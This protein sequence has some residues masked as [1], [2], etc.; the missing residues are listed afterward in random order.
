MEPSWIKWA[1]ELSAI[2]Q[3]GLEHSSGCFD[4][5]RYRS[6]QSI[7]ADIMAD[8]SSQRPE[9]VRDLFAREAGYATPKVDV[10]GAVFRNNE[11]MLVRERSDGL[12][13]LPG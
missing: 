9:F 12:W 1:R 11:I 2:A 10:R 5:E 7:A 8:H 13:S 4:A 3:I 6:V